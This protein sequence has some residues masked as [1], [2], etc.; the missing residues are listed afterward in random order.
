VGIEHLL[1]CEVHED[2]FSV[3]ALQLVRLRV[4]PQSASQRLHEVPL[5]A[6]DEGSEG[7]RG[8]QP[9]A[10]CDQLLDMGVLSLSTDP[11]S[12]FL[13]NVFKTCIHID[14]KWKNIVSNCNVK[15]EMRTS[16][17]NKYTLYEDEYAFDFVPSET[18]KFMLEHRVMELSVHSL[19]INVTYSDYNKETNQMVRKSFER[20]FNVPVSP[21]F[22]I[23]VKLLQFSDRT[24]RTVIHLQN[25]TKTHVSVEEVTVVTDNRYV[26]TNGPSEFLSSSSSATATTTT[27]TSASSSSFISQTQSLTPSSSSSSSFS[28]PK[29]PTATSVAPVAMP[30]NGMTPGEKRSFV[31]HVKGVTE[32]ASGIREIGYVRVKWRNGLYGASITNGPTLKRKEEQKEP[33]FKLELVAC[34]GRVT[35]EQPFAVTFRVSNLARVPLSLRLGFAD[36][37]GAIMPFGEGARNLGE[38]K[39]RSSKEVSVQ[40]ISLGLGVQKLTS[41]RLSCTLPAKHTATHTYDDLHRPMCV[42]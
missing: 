3:R 2:M 13:G 4:N 33:L 42:K 20:F 30:I 15:V 26:V 7:K 23:G 18:K 29:D 37:V 19:V 25:L 31:V 6:A 21:P 8:I 11:G 24:M 27:T 16:S 39:E 28:P 36:R 35:L 10:L 32:G 17:G 22:K 38:L 14:H 1:P 40:F 5:Q 9:P 41:V 34:P 12:V